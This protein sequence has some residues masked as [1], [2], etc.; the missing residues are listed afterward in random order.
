M[1]SRLHGRVVR[2][3]PASTYEAMKRERERQ[4]DAGDCVGDRKLGPVPKC[5][6]NGDS[7][8]CRVA[9]SRHR[10]LT[11]NGR[12]LRLFFNSAREIKSR[13]VPFPIHIT[14]GA[15]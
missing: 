7:G 8:A 12:A 14:R 15:S 9:L 11:A 10:L 4:H 2:V 13:P 3:L 1:A 5:G 6:A